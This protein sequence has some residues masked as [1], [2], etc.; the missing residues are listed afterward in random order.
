MLGHHVGCLFLFLAPTSPKTQSRPSTLY[1][2]SSSSCTPHPETAGLKLL[3]L[4][5]GCVKG[6]LS[7]C[8]PLNSNPP[9]ALSTFVPHLRWRI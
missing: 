5:I 7:S 6:V 8:L 2:Q 1:H 3:R 4:F 9:K